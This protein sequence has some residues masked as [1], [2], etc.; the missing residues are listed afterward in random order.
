VLR[1]HEELSS[2]QLVQAPSSCGH[3]A[4]QLGNVV[5]ILKHTSRTALHRTHRIRTT[6]TLRSPA[7]AAT[8]ST[9]LLSPSHRRQGIAPARASITD[10]LGTSMGLS[11]L[12]PGSSLASF[13]RA[14]D[15]FSAARSAARRAARSDGFF[16][17]AMLRHRNAVPPCE[18]TARASA[19]LRPGGWL[20]FTYRKQLGVTPPSRTGGRFHVAL[21]ERRGLTPPSRSGGRLQVT[22]RERRGLTP[23]SRTGGKRGRRRGA[24]AGPP[25]RPPCIP[26]PRPPAGARCMRTERYVDERISVPPLAHP[27]RGR[28]P[29]GWGRKD[30]ILAQGCRDR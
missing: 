23:P 20:R 28:D 30:A 12:P 17:A 22:W 8:C 4:A 21:C 14:T 26:P 24:S 10:A 19:G 13:S 29:R 7:V 11:G 27:L 16:G 3:G 1:A 6:R 25:S 15:S 18:V 5:P 9:T 2:R